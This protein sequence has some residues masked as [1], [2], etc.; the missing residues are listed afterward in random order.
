MGDTKSSR[1]LRVHNEIA[2]LLPQLN[3]LA[4]QGEPIADAIQRAIANLAQID[5]TEPYDQNDIIPAPA[6][7]QDD[8]PDAPD[9]GLAAIMERLA[10]MEQTILDRIAAQP[11]QQAAA[12]PA[13]ILSTYQL[14]ERSGIPFGQLAVQAR[15]SG[16]PLESVLAQRTGFKYLGGGNFLKH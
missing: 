4:R 16:S 1:M 11:Q 12:A 13:E 7:N 2:P 15:T 3:E 9:P 10:Q 6:D 5:R 14:I 8:R